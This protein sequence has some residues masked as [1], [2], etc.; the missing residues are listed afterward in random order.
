MTDIKELKNVIKIVPKLRSVIGEVRI[1]K[2]KKRDR[3]RP[4]EMMCQIC[5]TTFPYINEHFPILHKYDDGNHLLRKKCKPCYSKYTKKYYKK[6]PKK[7]KKLREK[8]PFKKYYEKHREKMNQHSKDYYQKNKER[9][10]ERL[11]K[12]YIENKDKIKIKHKEYYER[13]KQL[14]KPKLENSE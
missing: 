14:K 1:K 11:K 8:H 6:N 10:K 12:F 3:I 5:K 7:I 9:I 4:K 13:T 2:R